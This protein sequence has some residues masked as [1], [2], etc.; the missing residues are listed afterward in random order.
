MRPETNLAQ[1]AVP[2][3]EPPGEERA[4]SCPRRPP[5]S[6][7][8]YAAD[9][10]HAALGLSAGRYNYAVMEMAGKTWHESISDPGL[11][12]QVTELHPG[13]SSGAPR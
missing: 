12:F 2:G 9:S 13:T 5:P 11:C 10:A 7:P 8:I 1:V 6:L 4:G 3:T